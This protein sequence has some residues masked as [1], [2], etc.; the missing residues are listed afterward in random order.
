MN[1]L[2]GLLARLRSA[3]MQAEVGKDHPVPDPD[4][5]AAAEATEKAGAIAEEGG[6]EREAA[7]REGSCG[8]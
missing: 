3:E 1:R 5:E 2:P 7:R 4:E 6:E 8:C